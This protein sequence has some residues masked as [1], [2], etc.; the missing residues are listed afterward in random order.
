MSIVVG[1]ASGHLGRRVAEY[2]LDRLPVGEL[3]LVTRHPDALGD[4]AARGA[5][6]R[7]GD[8]DRPDTLA[9]AFAGG[10]S[11]LLIST[12][13][14][15]R[16]VTQHREAIGAARAAGIERIAYTSILSPVPANPAV[17]A[18]SHRA[19]EQALQ[20]SGL[21]WTVLRNG[22]YAEYQ[23]PEALRS[24]ATGKLVHNRG[25]GKVAY[26]SRDDCAAAAAAVLTGSAH[27]GV[28]YDITGPERFGAVELASLF[29]ELGGRP[30]E[31]VELDDESFKS[32]LIGDATGDDHLVYGAELVTS[33]G[34]AIREGHL[35]ACTNAVAELT[36]RPPRTLHDVL[37][38]HRAELQ[39]AASSA[40]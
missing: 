1:G 5:A 34:R 4:L 37:A 8:Y 7:H 24:L 39:A 23:V 28:A 2:L 12:D 17:A 33:F 27:D 31:V 6:V 16:R 19:T 20:E 11:L 26:V 15:D 9:D 35:S 13:A 22:L 18:P 10:T 29:E 21:A 25:T 3:V 14:L 40:A 30:V 32:G 36:G 38:A